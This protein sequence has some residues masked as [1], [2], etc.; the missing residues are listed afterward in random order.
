[1]TKPPQDANVGQRLPWRS[2]PSFPPGADSSESQ[3]P[4][5]Y[6][7]QTY[8]PAD[9][10]KPDV[11]RRSSRTRRPSHK[12]DIHRSQPSQSLFKEGREQCGKR[13]AVDQ[14]Y[15]SRGPNLDSTAMACKNFDASHDLSPPRRKRPTPY[16][17]TSEIRILVDAGCSKV[18]IA[19]VDG[20]NPPIVLYDEQ[21]GKYFHLASEKKSIP[22]RCKD[23]DSA[24][25]HVAFITA[26]DLDDDRIVF[27]HAKT[28][29]ELDDDSLSRALEINF[30][31]RELALLGAAISPDEVRQA[32][33]A[34]LLC[35]YVAAHVR[36]IF[37]RP[38]F[39]GREA[40]LSR[41]RIAA[42]WQYQ[43]VYDR[44]QQCYAA[45]YGH[46]VPMLV[47]TEPAMVAVAASQ[48][49]RPGEV[50]VVGD[51]GGA[52]ADLAQ[53]SLASDCTLGVS[54]PDM[55]KRRLLFTT[56]RSQSSIKCLVDAFLNENS[57]FAEWQTQVKGEILRALNKVDKHSL[58]HNPIKLQET[59]E[60][61]STARNI[62]KRARSFIA[63]T[64]KDL[65][66]RDCAEIVEKLTNMAKRSSSKGK[67]PHIFLCG[68]G[69]NNPQIAERLNSEQYSITKYMDSERLHRS[70]V[71][72]G[73]CALETK[74]VSP[75][76]FPS[77]LFARQFGDG[78]V[79]RQIDIPAGTKI[80]SCGL[81]SFSFKM[82]EGDGKPED[83]PNV[84][85]LDENGDR[86]IGDSFTIYE[87]FPQLT[88]VAQQ[89]GFR[90]QIVTDFAVE[91]GMLILRIFSHKK[92]DQFVNI[93]GK[94]TKC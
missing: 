51:V 5:S 61:G 41:I 68:G 9:D 64:T 94:N 29:C 1:M 82:F 22:K 7:V 38:E 77:S 28:F 4:A 36:Y 89:K 15:S 21:G 16:D 58:H 32:A 34:S 18:N 57:Q 63:A 59:I 19:A 50:G 24:E 8:S 17:N 80:E 69:C 78:R 45:R 74:A 47:N 55:I 62:S 66:N 54:E 11:L 12:F 83:P 70:V 87:L 79:S 3:T 75:K 42:P 44:V 2:H 30:V 90:A 92:G 60:S 49:L 53:V 84:C 81:T 56:L 27:W 23:P 35:T 6:S 73:L 39:R 25:I 48:A 31:Q 40:Q 65:W 52:T 37:T 88:Q 33:S 43:M 76:M 13:K 93:W 86:S 85:F 14:T 91:H 72:R 71:L 26:A 46:Q 67:H 20:S 10:N